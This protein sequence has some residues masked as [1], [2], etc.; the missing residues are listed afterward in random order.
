MKNRNFFLRA[1]ALT[2]IVFCSIPLVGQNGLHPEEKP[3]PLTAELMSAKSQLE[4]AIIELESLAKLPE[5]DFKKKH[6]SIRKRILEGISELKV[7]EKHLETVSR[8]YEKEIRKVASAEAKSAQ[9]NAII[10]HLQTNWE[11]EIKALRKGNDFGQIVAELNALEKRVT[12]FAEIMDDKRFVLIQAECYHLIKVYATLQAGQKA[13]E[14]PF[15]AL[16]V[17]ELM[18]ELL[19]LEISEDYALNGTR[20]HLREL[21]RNYQ[22]K[23]CIALKRVYRPARR[24]AVD[25]EY[26]QKAREIIDQHYGRFKEYPYIQAELKRLRKSP[27]RH[28]CNFGTLDCK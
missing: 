1:F 14:K 24:M 7:T 28:R 12:G 22:N 9:A 15:Y 10:S 6:D 3:N 13:L 27:M 4:I 17:A 11:K 20:L 25:F 21:L 2:T 19:R 5:K 18:E 26:P 8:R 23:S 16:R